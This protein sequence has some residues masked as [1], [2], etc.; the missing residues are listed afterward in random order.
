[1]KYLLLIA[2]VVAVIWLTRALRGKPEAPAAPKPAASSGGHEDMVACTHCGIHL[3]RSEATT[4]AGAAL[5]CGEPHRLV[6]EGKPPGR[7]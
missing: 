7:A 1:M 6:H 4:G 2:I 5:Y 3:P